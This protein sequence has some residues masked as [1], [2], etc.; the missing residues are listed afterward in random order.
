MRWTSPPPRYAP[1]RMRRASAR[2]RAWPAHVAHLWARA[3]QARAVRDIAVVTSWVELAVGPQRL[4]I[5]VIVPTRN[6]AHCVGTAIASVVAQRHSRWEL[7]VVD[8]GS[9]DETPGILAAIV[10]DRVKVLHTKGG[11]VAT[12]RNRG[13]A[14]ASGDI[15]VYLDDDNVMHPLW[16]HAVAW[17][18]TVFPD[19]NS[20]YGARVVE[21]DEKVLGLRGGRLPEVHFVPFNRLVLGFR[22]YI[23][24]GVF[25]H[26]R[27]LPGAH[28]DESLSQAADWD[29]V[30]RMTADS[31]PLVLPVVANL[32]S[33]RGPQRLTRSEGADEDGKRIAAMRR[34]RSRGR[35]QN[36]DP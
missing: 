2:P 15:V 29:L 21:G 17:A 18:F 22:N 11:G 9:A 34:S 16:L 20:L 33:T 8:D 1:T 13:L 5:S 32:Y 28:F 12:A 27:E 25:A 19:I 30:R 24:M 36:R 14:L 26:R 3:A 23:D 6:R 35:A 31:A 10:D 7:I 4:V